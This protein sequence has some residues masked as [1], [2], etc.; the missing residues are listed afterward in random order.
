MLGGLRNICAGFLVQDGYNG[1]GALVVCGSK[2]DVLEVTWN[3]KTIAEQIVDH[4]NET[5]KSGDIL[6]VNLECEVANEPTPTPVVS[7]AAI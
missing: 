1:G 3:V 6:R 4:L 2:C 7:H 5:S